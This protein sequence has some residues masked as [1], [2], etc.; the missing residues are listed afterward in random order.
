MAIV[1]F[2]IPKTLEKRV[3]EVIKTKGFASKAEFFRFAAVFF[4]D[5]VDKPYISEDERFDYLSQAIR[6]EVVQQYKNKKIP[7][8]E[9][10][11]LNS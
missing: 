3:Q 4:M 1:N 2:S 9:E 6:K 7:S 5:V 10:Q 11:L 8:L